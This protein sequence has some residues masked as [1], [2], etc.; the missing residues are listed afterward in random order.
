MSIGEEKILILEKE[1]STLHLYLSD[2]DL[3]HTILVHIEH[4]SSSLIEWMHLHK[5]HE[6]FQSLES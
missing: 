6:L 5:P 1:A 4:F 3:D 2:E